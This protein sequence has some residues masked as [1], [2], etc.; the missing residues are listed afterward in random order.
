MAG[1]SWTSKDVVD[2]RRKGAAERSRHMADVTARM[3]DEAD[4]ALGMRVLELGAGTGEMALLLSQRVGPHGTVVATDVSAP[5]LG[6]DARRRAR[7]REGCGRHERGPRGVRRVGGHAPGVELRCGGRAQRPDVSGPGRVP[8]LDMAGDARGGQI[9]GHRVGSRR[10]QLVSRPR[11]RSG[12]RRGRVG[13]PPAGASR[14]RSLAG[15]A[16]R[17]R[18]RSPGQ[19]FARSGRIR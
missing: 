5:M 12:A 7:R 19:G 16:R 6:A 8:A 4:I 17:T 18:R 2:Q 11:A 9:R 13:R 3:F 10:E 15:R 1:T 14:P